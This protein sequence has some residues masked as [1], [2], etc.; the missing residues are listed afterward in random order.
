MAV[1][2]TNIHVSCYSCWSDFIRNEKGKRNEMV[3][4]VPDKG[5]IGRKEW[6]FPNIPDTLPQ[7]DEGQ[8]RA[9]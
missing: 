8:V 6:N 5:K 7:C 9:Y 3:S 1:E 2:E 4:I